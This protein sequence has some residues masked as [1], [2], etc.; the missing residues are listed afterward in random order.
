MARIR[1]IC[2]SYDDLHNPWYA[3]GGAFA[4]HEVAKRLAVI[5]DVTVL[6][7]AYP[8]A[9]NRMIDGVNYERAGLRWGGPHLGQLWFALTLPF[10]AWARR[11]SFDLWIESF[12]PPWSVSGVPL[13]VKQPVIG[14]VHMLAGEDMWRKYHMPF[15]LIERIG[16]RAY[17]NIVVLTE[18]MRKTIHRYHPTASIDVIPNG[19][20]IPSPE[21]HP[22]AKRHVLFLGRI[23]M[24]QK[25]LDLLIDAYRRVA[26]HISHPLVIAGGGAKR[27]VHK[28]RSHI[29]A[30]GLA[31]RIS[32]VGRVEGEQKAALLRDA[33]VVVLP[34]RFET[35]GSVA[36]EAMAYGIPV[37]CFDIDM[38]HWIPEQCAFKARPFSTDDLAA[39]IERALRSKEHV[40]QRCV[41]FAARYDW[42]S[43][44]NAYASV[45]ERCMPQHASRKPQHT[46]AGMEDIVHA[47][48]DRHIPC[49]FIAPHLDDAAL[50]AGGLISYLAD[51]TD[52]TI[53]TVFTEG[54]SGAAGNT[55][56]ARR[57]LAQVGYR[58]AEKLYADR[59]AEDMDVCRE[60]G[61][62]WKHLG[63]TDALWRTIP[64]PSIIRRT[65]GTFLPEF[66]HRHPTFRL[67]IARKNVADRETVA[68]V[69]RRLRSEFP[70][71]ERYAVFA[72]FS[73]DTHIDHMTVRRACEEAFSDP[74]WW[75]DIPYRSVDDAFGADTDRYICAIYS[76]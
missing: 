5:N 32:L 72:P 41:E 47:I 16:L 14:L 49:L 29:A 52:V 35:F 55:L 64:R 50:S 27:E 18:E 58:D 21:F 45:I 56:S 76:G 8:G 15:F 30:A 70:D 6:T 38:L 3:G 67:H 31:H 13:A 74:I 4:V 25:G 51:K 65:L 63:F 62:S 57:F 34:S 37:V 66:L 26:P 48:V 43:A 69:V 42:A 44:A 75:I 22:G 33:A 1:I 61:V 20:T 36:L 53:A 71:G 12:G 11:A 7:G 2:S 59:R 23:E 28:L 68:D 17:R 10:R 40:A 39:Q 54:G 46:A 73:L 60:I 19:V 24:N 9:E